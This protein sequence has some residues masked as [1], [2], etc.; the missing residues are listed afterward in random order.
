MELK[1]CPNETT[2]MVQLESL[3]KGLYETYD[4]ILVKIDEQAGHTKTFLRWLCFSVRP[5]KLAEISETIVVN[6]DAADGPRHIPGNRYFDVRDVL[7]KCSGLINLNES[8]GTHPVGATS[9]IFTEKDNRTSQAG[10]LLNQGISSF[11]TPPHR[12]HLAFPFG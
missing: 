12:K 4:R 8:E 1:K 2:V 5:M 10:T 3:P 7:A 9:L 6:L 11:R